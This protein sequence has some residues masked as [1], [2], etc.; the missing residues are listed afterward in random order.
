VAD[1]LLLY[2]P[3]PTQQPVVEFLYNHVPPPKVG[4]DS[5]IVASSLQTITT[6]YFSWQR[7]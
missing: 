7:P 5:K 3:I 2:D 4:Q 1:F 6:L